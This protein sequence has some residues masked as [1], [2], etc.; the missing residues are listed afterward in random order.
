[1]KSPGKPS[2]PDRWIV[3]LAVACGVALLV[4]GVRFLTVPHQATRFFGIANPPRPFDLHLVVGLRDL[5]LAALL[6][7]LALLSEWRALALCLS[8]GAVVCLGDTAIVAISSGRAEA[9]AFH[10]ASGIYCGVLSW[11]AWRR[12][13]RSPNF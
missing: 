12:H 6:I 5:W 9:I 3:G 7:G 13:G 11:A 4:I 10:L 1:M 2:T 8:L